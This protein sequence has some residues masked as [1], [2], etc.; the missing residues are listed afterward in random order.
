MFIKKLLVVFLALVSFVYAENFYLQNGTKLINYRLISVEG[1]KYEIS[2]EGVDQAS[3]IKQIDGK[4]ILYIDYKQYDSTKPSLTTNVGDEIFTEIESLKSSSQINRTTVTNA[5]EYV[6]ESQNKISQNEL[7][8]FG[9]KL[10]RVNNV[11]TGV[12]LI[13]VGVMSFAFGIWANSYIQDEGYDLEKERNMLYALGA[14]SSGLGI[15]F[16]TYE[17]KDVEI[18][19][20]FNS[21]SI[22]YKF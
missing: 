6:P 16:I 18:N 9:N 22:S 1:D 3:S 19:S 20:S 12:S 11:T 13:G 15:F 4:V 21:L 8:R 2:S 7:I 17:N 14:I 5:K 10:S